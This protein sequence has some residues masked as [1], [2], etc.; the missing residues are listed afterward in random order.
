M[1]CRLEIGAAYVLRK[2]RVEA[3]DSYLLRRINHLG[4][5]IGNWTMRKV[6]L[7]EK[8]GHAETAFLGICR[9]LTLDPTGDMRHRMARWSRTFL[10]RWIWRRG[11][12]RTVLGSVV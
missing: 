9:S 8:D 2:K 3:S 10:E 6:W 12:K 11:L 5:C 7:L 4:N 1:T